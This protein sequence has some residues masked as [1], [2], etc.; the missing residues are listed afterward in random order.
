LA[1]APSEPLASQ[2]LAIEPPTP[3]PSASPP[4]SANNRAGGPEE[5][6]ITTSHPTPAH[7]IA[8]G[9]PAVT[10]QADT[11]RI[12][13]SAP[14]E[15]AVVQTASPTHSPTPSS[16]S[17]PAEQLAPVLISI[18]RDPSG[19]RHMT[20]QIQP[21]ALG[22]LQIQIDHTPGSS[23]RVQIIVE[24]PETLAL[25]QRDTPQLL[26]ALD[27]AGVPRDGM[28]F[29]FHAAPS[30]VVS[31]LPSDNSVS[32]QF[33]GFGPPN[34]GFSDGRPNR[35][36]AHVPDGGDD[37]VAAVGAAPARGLLSNLDI[38]A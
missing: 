34:Q 19:E 28:T 20:L 32:T 11:A 7:V 30:A 25:L 6:A 23:L 37:R 18:A 2:P 15:P 33:P 16:G 36:L 12:L 13:L 24:R 26:R 35:F 22:H 8:D 5:Q 4:A 3:G 14:P 38:I 17:A 21:E 27:Q 1:F 10:E 31:P 9:T 29:N